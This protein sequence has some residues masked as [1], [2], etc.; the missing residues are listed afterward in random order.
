MQRFT[1]H[2]SLLLLT[3][4]V[5][6]L[7]SCSGKGP[8][9]PAIDFDRVAMLENYGSNNLLPA[10]QTLQATVDNLQDSAN[11][12]TTEPTETNLTALQQQ[13]KKTRLA[14][15][16]A[17]LFQFGPAESQTLRTSLNTYPVDTTQV[18]N[19]IESGSYTLGTLENRAAS[20]LPTLGYLLH[21]IGSTNSEIVAGYSTDSNA[22][23]RAQYLLDN[24]SFIKQKVDNTLTAWQSSGDDYLAT[25]TSEEN[26][27][28]DTGS[29]L[30]MMVNALVL[31]YERF[32]RDG[33]IGIPAGV[34]SSGV[35]RP[36]AVEAYYAGYSI[37]LAE[38][39][40]EAVKRLFKGVALDGTDGIGLREYLVALDANDLATEITARLDSSSLALQALSDPLSEQ[41]KNN[42]QPVLHTFEQMQQVVT[43]LKADM[44]SILGVTITFQDNDGD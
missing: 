14:W 34:R 40:N 15:Q 26:S 38:A 29:S 30:G 12:F 37:A 11:S 32:V 36:T 9:G 1:N 4:S 44:T 31:H 42:N 3:L 19:N 17:N 22:S 27:G 5:L 23:N 8:N 7:A 21:G 35:I 39:N 41:I 28:T 2:F 10:Y 18:E 6:I 13:L 16:D 20:G 33:K 43:L 25:F 24:I